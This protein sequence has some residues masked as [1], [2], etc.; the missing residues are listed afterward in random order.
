MAPSGV[1]PL[2]GGLGRPHAKTD[3]LALGKAS[4]HA[5][6][7]QLVFGLDQFVHP[8]GRR[9]QSHAALLLADCHAETREQ[10]RLVGATLADEHDWL[11]AFEVAS[12]NGLCFTYGLRRY[13]SY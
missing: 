2:R 8:G 5:P 9:P 12:V 6:Q 3:Q 1:D 13:G 7:L 11:G 10:V 4:Q